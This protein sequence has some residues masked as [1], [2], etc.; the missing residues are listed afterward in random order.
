MYTFDE[1]IF[2]FS[3]SRMTCCLLGEAASYLIDWGMSWV[4]VFF[5][6]KPSSFISGSLLTI[7]LSSLPNISSNLE[8]SL[9]FYVFFIIDFSASSLSFSWSLSVAS[10][11]S[12]IS[13]LGCYLISL[14]SSM[15]EFSWSLNLSASF[16]FASFPFS[17][18]LSLSPALPPG[19]PC[20]TSFSYSRIDRM[21]E[22]EFKKGLD[23]C[24]FFSLITDD[25]DA[26]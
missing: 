4:W 1:F 10:T 26:D 19:P 2:C 13:S 24:S 18:S 23:D 15:C 12:L 6:D 9:F 7:W 8:V 14:R 20:L 22:D 16:S 21:K 5:I 3:I 25:N 17:L 11:F